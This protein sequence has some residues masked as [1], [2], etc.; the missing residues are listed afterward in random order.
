MDTLAEPD[1]GIRLA[2]AVTVRFIVSE[3]VCQISDDV[4][5]TTVTD[6]V[7]P[8]LSGESLCEYGYARACEE[9]YI[10]PFCGGKS[11]LKRRRRR[12]TGSDTLLDV[13]IVV[14]S[15]INSTIPWSE[16]TCVV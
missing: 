12:Q 13:D 14:S 6:F 5:S 4:L 15:A 11:E 2:K 10:V 7:I 16:G 9:E 1:V 3:D 8:Q